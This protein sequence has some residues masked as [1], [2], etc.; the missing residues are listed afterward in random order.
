MN[1]GFRQY[2]VTSLG[3]HIII[4]Y[5]YKFNF[6]KTFTMM[7]VVSSIYFM[8]Y[9]IS[10]TYILI[11]FVIV[12]NLLTMTWINHMVIIVIIIESGENITEE[13]EEEHNNNQNHTQEMENTRYLKNF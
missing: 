11:M 12:L 7:S 4:V 13:H 2:L 5:F 3:F 8:H 9:T 1:I 6:V 10:N